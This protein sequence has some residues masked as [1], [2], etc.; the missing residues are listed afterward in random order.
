MLGHYSGG[1][2]RTTITKEILMY[3]VKNWKKPNCSVKVSVD[4]LT[5]RES[6]SREINET[7]G[8]GGGLNAGYDVVEAVAIA[9]GF[10][11]S[12]GLVYG[13]DFVFKT[14][15]FNQIMFDFKDLD[16]ANRAAHVLNGTVQNIEDAVA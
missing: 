5:N 15:S 11:S 16:T 3:E 2:Y 12:E 9:S 13:T 4:S 10:L 1:L 8:E 7:Y 6:F 14:R